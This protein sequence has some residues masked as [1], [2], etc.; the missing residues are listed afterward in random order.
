MAI[1][2]RG[3]PKVGRTSGLCRLQQ[4]RAVLPS[5]STDPSER[6]PSQRTPA[7]L[8]Q[9][10]TYGGGLALLQ[11]RAE[12]ATSSLVENSASK[13]GGGLYMAT[14]AAFDNALLAVTGST[15][16]RNQVGG[17]GGFA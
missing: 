16:R 1:S 6:R 15:L 12:L 7:A 10:L 2:E 8:A 13:S 14:G 3:G 17:C 5:P 4:P 11:V 9:A